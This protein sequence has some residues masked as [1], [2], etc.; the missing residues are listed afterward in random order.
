MQQNN[1]QVPEVVVPSMVTICGYGSLLSE[2]S[3]R[4]TTPSIKNFRKAKIK[5]YKRVFNI[6][7]ISLIISG[8]S[9]LETK[10][11]AAVCA[12]PS[13]DH[14]LFVTLFDIPFE[15]L[16]SLH[17]RE[18]RFNIIEVD[19]EE[20]DLITNTIRISKALMCVEMTDEE[21]KNVKCKSEEEYF[22]R[23]G[24][25]YSGKLWR[26]DVLP[27]RKYLKFN[28][29]SAKKLGQDYYDNYLDTSFLA[30]KKTTIREYLESH[31]DILQ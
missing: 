16:N 3:A 28:L 14:F 18:H 25:H 9:N 7:A 20:I 6:V 17:E 4:R 22:E 21:Y 31:P 13:S 26:E 30:D 5:G 15:E 29:E 10:E 19:A 24:K 2:T 27:N 8:Q 1:E 11:V 12:V 23:V